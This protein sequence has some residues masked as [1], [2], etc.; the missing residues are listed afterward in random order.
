MPK[1]LVIDDEESFTGSMHR[2]LRMVLPNEWSVEIEHAP[3]TGLSRV[4][5]DKLIRICFVDFLMSDPEGVGM[6]GDELI[7]HAL[8]LR[9]EM[10][11]R[12]IVC[13]GWYFDGRME[14]RLF[15]EL[16]CLRLDKPPEF[17]K[18]QKIVWSLIYSAPV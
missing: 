12:I 5:L 17:E 3:S 6:D 4:V 2:L 8:K 9:P 10:R 16:G 13:S 14:Q 18:L 7:E 15:G 1:V 11:G